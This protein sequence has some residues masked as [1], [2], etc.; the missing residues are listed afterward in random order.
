MNQ[1][2][3]FKKSKTKEDS[4]SYNKTPSGP[5]FARM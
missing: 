5:N 3:V 2:Q 4:Q 1:E